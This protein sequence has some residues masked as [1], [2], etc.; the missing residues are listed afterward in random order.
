MGDNDLKIYDK[1]LLNNGLKLHT[2]KTVDMLFNK[3]ILNN[4]ITIKLK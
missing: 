2:G 4:N 1:W 3:K